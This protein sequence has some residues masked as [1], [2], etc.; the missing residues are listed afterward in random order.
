MSRAAVFTA[1][2]TDPDLI[3]MGIDEDHVFPNYSMDGRPSDGKFLILR[4]EESTFNSQTYTGM[5]NGMKRAP[6]V[7]T[8][9]AHQPLE[10]SNDFGEI[11]EI[12]S[13]VEDV[14]SE[15]EHVAGA[16]GYTVTCVQPNGK[17]R[18]LKDD[19]FNTIC[20][21]STFGVLSRKTET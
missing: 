19:A 7:L 13:R 17:S 11:D 14:L 1:L 12:L 4:W 9:W 16:D 15:L 3:E 6:R 18:D 20:R 2:T 5:R 8:V 10:I 21:T